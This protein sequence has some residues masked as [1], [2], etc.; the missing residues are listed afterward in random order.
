M[1]FIDSENHSIAG[2]AGNV[3]FSMDDEGV[4]EF[5]DGTGYQVTWD[6]NAS[7]MDPAVE[8]N[9]SG[10]ET[11]SLVE[12]V[13]TLWPERSNLSDEGLFGSF[14]LFAGDDIVF[15]SAAPWGFVDGYQD[16]YPAGEI[17]YDPATFVGRKFV[18]GWGEFS[19][20]YTYNPYAMK[21]TLVDLELLEDSEGLFGGDPEPYIN[22]FLRD[23]RAKEKKVLGLSGGA[24]NNW[25]GD[26][27]PPGT[28]LLL[29]TEMGRNWFYGLQ[30]DGYEYMGIEVR[31]NDIRGDDWLM[32]P[33]TRYYD[34]F[35][36]TKYLDFLNTNMFVTIDLP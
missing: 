15:E 6:W 28:L 8:G 22:L 4:V 20:T 16:Q 33:A 7:T 21:V 36:G 19:T 27:I 29:K 17:L 13:S 25:K 31:E 26:G 14:G 23:G 11:Y 2:K 24:Q 32:I 3:G 5:P 34:S 35:G 30:V 1:I 10:T 18:S 12:M 9:L